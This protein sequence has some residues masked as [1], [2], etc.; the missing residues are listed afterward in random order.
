M[1]QGVVGDFCQVKQ[2]VESQLVEGF[3]IF[4]TLLNCMTGDRNL[5]VGEG[6]KDIGVIGAGRISQA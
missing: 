1:A 3:D 4:Q 6:V 5:V 2:P